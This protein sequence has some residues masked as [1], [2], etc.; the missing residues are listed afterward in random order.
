MSTLVQTGRFC[1]LTQGRQAGKKAVILA[2]YPEGSEARKFPHAIVLG[3]EKCPRK[4][5]KEMSQDVLVKRTQVKAF[6]KVVNFNHILLTRH[7]A[8]ED[9]FNTIDGEKLIRAMGDTAEKK[10]TIEGAQAALRQKYLNNMYNWFFQPL[11]F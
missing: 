11:H 10:A 4:L 9:F 8:K 7:T 5:N 1:I 6:I 2:A 3:V